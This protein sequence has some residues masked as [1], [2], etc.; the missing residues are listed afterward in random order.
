M[1]VA[2]TCYG[3]PRRSG[4]TDNTS[5]RMS[6][7]FWGLTQETDLKLKSIKPPL[8]L[9]SLSLYRHVLSTFFFHLLSV[10]LS[11][12]LPASFLCRSSFLLTSFTLSLLCLTF[13]ILSSHSVSQFQFHFGTTCGDRPFLLVH[14]RTLFLHYISC[15]I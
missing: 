3:F 8:S 1:P 10:Y 6:A 4:N 5:E 11:I 14:N 2:P 7:T 15:Q 12:A 13:S 9:L